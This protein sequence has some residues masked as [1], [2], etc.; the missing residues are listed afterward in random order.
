MIAL[1]A[2]INV[3]TFITRIKTF[4]LRFYKS[5]FKTLKTLNNNVNC[6]VIS[7]PLRNY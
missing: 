1:P 5:I 4:K 2:T 7:D 6:K 3:E